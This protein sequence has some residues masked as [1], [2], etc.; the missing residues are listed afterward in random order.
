MSFDKLLTVSSQILACTAAGEGVHTPILLV[1]T[2]GGAVKR[3]GDGPAPAEPTPEERRV[4]H[5][6]KSSSLITGKSPPTVP[7]VVGLDFSTTKAPRSKRVGSKAGFTPLYPTANESSTDPVEESPAPSS[8]T[9]NRDHVPFRR[10]L[11]DWLQK[12]RAETDTDL[13]DENHDDKSATADIAVAT[14]DTRP[15]RSQSLRGFVHYGSDSKVMFGP[16][17]VS[18]F[19]AS[20]TRTQSYESRADYLQ[21][22]LYS[23]RPLTRGVGSESAKKPATNKDDVLLRDGLCVPL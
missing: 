16:K 11:D 12:R 14:S 4:L 8:N 20:G 5:K 3:W 13:S 17:M 9:K 19:A 6:S 15:T 1:S 23:A 7:D 2:L 22:E 21:D 18:L 10:T